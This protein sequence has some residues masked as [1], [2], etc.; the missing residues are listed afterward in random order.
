[1]LWRQLTYPINLDMHPTIL[2]MGKATHGAVPV[3]KYMLPGLWSVHLY[4]YEAESIINGHRLP[5]RPGYAEVA[6][7][8]AVVEYRLRGPS[9]H[10][11][12]HFSVP[13]STHSIPIRAMQD[14]GDQFERLSLGFEEALASRRT[15]PRRSDARL[16]DILWDLALMGNKRESPRFTEFVGFGTDHESVVLT[17]MTMIE[18][19]MSEPL[20]VGALARELNISHNHLTRCFKA[21][22][23][24][25]VVGYILKRRIE[26]ARLLLEHSA[27]PIKAVAEEVGI[28]DLQQFNKTV[29]RLLGASPSAVRAASKGF[30]SE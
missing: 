20:T 30:N 19:R 22:I 13:A 12:A 17:A 9:T 29:R 24:D 4:T 1:M 11:Y 14:T 8:G 28:P 2:L 7:P 10:W 23:G 25:T 6:P 21:G 26:H 5:I 16:W 15:N 3:E 27:K 18:V